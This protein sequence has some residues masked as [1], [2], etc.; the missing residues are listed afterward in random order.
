MASTF[1][2]RSLGGVQVGLVRA[3]NDKIEPRALHRREIVG[4]VH[5]IDADG[6]E[7]MA[8]P[9][10]G[11]KQQPARP[12]KTAAKTTCLEN[13]AHRLGQE[14]SEHTDIRFMASSP[15]KR[16]VAN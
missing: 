13:T 15:I 16:F 4:G 12:V 14:H 5:R 8:A 1:Q 6:I 11:T 3:A 9:G 2:T 7:G 10:C